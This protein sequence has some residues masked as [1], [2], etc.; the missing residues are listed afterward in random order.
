MALATRQFVPKTKTHV[1]DRILARLE[2][3]DRNW[4]LK[5]LDPESGVTS[6]WIAEQLEDEG[7]T[8]S[9]SSVADW[10]RRL[11]TKA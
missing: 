4:L 10:R 9:E 5:Q 7:F 1:V 8:C 6:V 2:D 3:N 11:K